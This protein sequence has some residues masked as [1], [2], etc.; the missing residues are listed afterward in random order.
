MGHPGR[1]RPS[2]QSRTTPGGQKGDRRS[3]WETGIERASGNTQTVTLGSGAGA[4]FKRTTLDGFGRVTRVEAGHDATTVSQMDTQYAPCACS[5][6][7]KLWRT[8]QPYAPGGT[9][10]W[11]T[12]A[13]D[14]SGRTLSVTAADGSVTRY[15]YSGN[16]T[17]ATDAAGK[18]KTSVSDAFGNLVQVIE[19]NPAGGAN[20]VTNY[21]YNGLNQ[22]AQVSMPRSNGTQTRTFAYSGLDMVSATNP[23]NGT[24]TYQYDAAHHVTQRT[25]NMGQQTR[26]SY[27]V[28]GRLTQVQHWAG[29]PLAEQINQRWNYYYDSNPYDGTYS[30]NTWGRLAAVDFAPPSTG[31]AASFTYQYMWFSRTLSAL[32]IPSSADPLEQLVEQDLTSLFE[33]VESERDVKLV[34]K[35]QPRYDRYTDAQIWAAIEKLRAQDS[36]APLTPKDLKLPEWELFSK[37][38]PAKNSANLRLRV[39]TPPAKYARGSRA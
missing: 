20:L 39:E 16:Q 17:T 28:Y 1:A 34:R 8:S 31:G 4:R 23:E 12:N 30:L 24:V 9:P 29:S 21:T 14:A 18:W 25:D 22:L 33:D 19:P 26:Y 38:D 15:S 11:S 3:F 13:Y 5:A 7:G 6:L 2:P 35:G 32:S 36:A 27:D 37:P 10:V